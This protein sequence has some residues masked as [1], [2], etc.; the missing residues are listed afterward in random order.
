MWG[1][2]RDLIF[3]VLVVG[4]LLLF[5][6]VTVFCLV[7][8]VIS[9][10]YS[11]AGLAT[12]AYI[13]S[14]R[15]WISP[16]VCGCYSVLSGCYSVLSACY[17]DAALGTEA[18]ISSACRWICLAMCGCY[19]V[20]SG[21]YSVFLSVTVMRASARELIFLVLVVGSLSVLLTYHLTWRLPQKDHGTLRIRF[22]GRLE[23]FRSV[24]VPAPPYGEDKRE[25]RRQILTSKVDPPHWKSNFFTMVIDP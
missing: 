7:D 18:D 6:V 1:S 3:L 15:R 10:C 17:S 5:V 4:S 16:A 25:D 23:I 8:S 2:A 13:A 24:V 11:D 20:L 22:D 21:C 14:T 12:G 19:S 9:V